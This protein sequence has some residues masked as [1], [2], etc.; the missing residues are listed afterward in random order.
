MIVFILCVAVTHL[1]P[2]EYPFLAIHVLIENHIEV[3]AR[4]QESICEYYKSVINPVKVIV[5]YKK[6]LQLNRDSRC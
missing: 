1:D 3:R 4:I 5:V 2:V 6:K